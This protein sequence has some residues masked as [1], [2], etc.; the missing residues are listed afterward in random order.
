MIPL[1]EMMTI[2]GY[3]KIVKILIENGAEVKS[4]NLHSAALNGMKYLV[5]F[6][7]VLNI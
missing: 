6:D 1:S 4:N 5:V 7:D 3:D 2:I